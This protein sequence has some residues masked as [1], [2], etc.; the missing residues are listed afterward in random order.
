MREGGR[1]GERG[2]GREGERERDGGRGE[3]KQSRKG[4][5]ERGE[6]VQELTS[7]LRSPAVSSTPTEQ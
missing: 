6:S 7:L 5:R 2:R 4:D 1:E 3:V